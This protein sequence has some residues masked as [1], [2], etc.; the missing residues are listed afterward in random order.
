M[1]IRNSVT[2]VDVINT[3]YSSLVQL[4]STLSIVR[5]TRVNSTVHTYTV[6]VTRHE[7]LYMYT[8]IDI[9]VHISFTV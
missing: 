9:T 7:S 8:T 2:L 1:Y 3:C 4:T 6:Y 5:S